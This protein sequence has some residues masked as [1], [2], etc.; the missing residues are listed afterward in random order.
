MT[1]KK[2]YSFYSKSFIKPFALLL[3]M[4][5]FSF[6]ERYRK[7][8]TFFVFDIF[9][10]KKPMFNVDYEQY[11]KVRRKHLLVPRFI[12][13]KNI[14]PFGSNV[15]DIGCGDGT[16]GAL[17]I[18]EKG[19]TVT[20]VDVSATAL[21][22]AKANGLKTV[23]ANFPDSPLPSN[24]FDYVVASEIIEHIMRPDILLLN[25]KKYENIIITIPNIGFYTHRLRLFFG[26]FPLQWAMYPHEHVSY[27]TVADFKYYLS[28]LGFSV[29]RTIGTN[30]IPLLKD[31]WPNLFSN[32]VLF[33]IKL[34]K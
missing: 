29:K 34:K 20:G 15:L 1:T 7:F 2:F 9:R 18:K 19:C 4:S 10:R 13:I 24:K 28:E 8:L 6:F 17:L 3:L 33:V 14:I 11:W 30:G 31:L 21:S 25:M 23:K 12:I 16:L 26:K 5:I 27:W 32:Q 22:Y